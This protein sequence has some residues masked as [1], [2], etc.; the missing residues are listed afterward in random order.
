MVHFILSLLACR[1]IRRKGD[2]SPFGPF[3]TVRYDG[4]GPV[5]TDRPLSYRVPENINLP[6]YTNR[7]APGPFVIARG[8][9]GIE[10]V[11]NRDGDTIPPEKA[12]LST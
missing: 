8:G 6:A 12:K 10:V 2:D 5:G 9:L 4:V 3:V 11:E 7:E 1:E